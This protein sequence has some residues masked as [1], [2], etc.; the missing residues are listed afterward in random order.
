MLNSVF[1]IVLE[2]HQI[3]IDISVEENTKIGYNYPL[4]LN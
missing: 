3:K 4:R 1:H 2:K